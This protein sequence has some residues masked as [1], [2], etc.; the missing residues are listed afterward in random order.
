MAYGPNVDQTQQVAG[1]DGDAALQRKQA[2]A[3]AG[4]R[5]TLWLA[6]ASPRWGD[7]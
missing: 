2:I 3:L 7:A 4:V 6:Q 5:W 1:Q